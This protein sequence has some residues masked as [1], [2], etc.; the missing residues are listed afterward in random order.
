MLLQQARLVSTCLGVTI[1]E[2]IFV[3]ESGVLLSRSNVE[4]PTGVARE[5]FLLFFVFLSTTQVLPNSLPDPKA[6]LC[7]RCFAVTVACQF[8]SD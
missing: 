2:N 1:V 7:N 8:S 4:G 3:A 6:P 5:V